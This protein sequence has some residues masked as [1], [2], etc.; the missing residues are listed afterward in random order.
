MG[1]DRTEETGEMMKQFQEITMPSFNWPT[2]GSL[3]LRKE[4]IDAEAHTL[5]VITLLLIGS[6]KYSGHFYNVI[7]VGMHCSSGIN[8]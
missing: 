7:S 1:V 8:L 6:I 5:S 4:Q 3:H 2:W